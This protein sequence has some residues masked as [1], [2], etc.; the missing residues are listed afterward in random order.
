M[1]TIKDMAFSSVEQKGSTFLGFLCPIIDFKET[2]QSLKKEHTKAV[3]FV[4]SSRFLN[5]HKQIQE[6]FSD[7]GEPKGSSGMPTL[8]VLR[9]YDIIEVGFVSVRYFGGTLLGVGGLT[10]AYSQCAKEALK[11][12]HIIP[13]QEIKQE[14]MYIPFKKLKYAYYLAKKFHIQIVQKDF[15]HQ[16]IQIICHGTE[17]DISSFKHAI[18]EG[19]LS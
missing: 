18:F 9:G 16:D 6:S 7:D 1:N 12:A 11:Q 19:S 15:I 14:D 8:K 17:Q 5:I 10:R 2:L 4:T 3:H 13:Y